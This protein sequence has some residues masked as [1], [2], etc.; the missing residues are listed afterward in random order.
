MKPEFSESSVVIF[1]FVCL[2]QIDPSWQNFGDTQDCCPQ[3]FLPLRCGPGRRISWDVPFW[4]TN[5]PLSGERLLGRPEQS[6]SR[7]AFLLS[8]EATPGLRQ[9]VQGPT[10]SIPGDPYG[11]A[12]PP[13]PTFQPIQSCRS[14][15][16]LER[17]LSFHLVNRPGRGRLGVE[18]ELAGRE[19]KSEGFTLPAPARG[20]LC[21]LLLLHLTP[22]PRLWGGRVNSGLPEASSRAG[23]LNGGIIHR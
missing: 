12:L 6:V 1:L 7:P 21:P 17:G 8:Q 20:T 4:G 16:C 5:I 3:H 15:G 14:L 13:P 19:G 11:Q 18:G 2:F 23:P 10:P 22:A 9:E